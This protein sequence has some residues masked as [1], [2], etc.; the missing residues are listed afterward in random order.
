[1]PTFSIALAPL[2]HVFRVDHALGAR[3]DEFTPGQFLVLAPTPLRSAPPVA[4]SSAALLYRPP[5][6]R[7][8]PRAAV[9]APAGCIHDRRVCCRS[10]SSCSRRCASSSSCCT[11]LAASCTSW[12]RTPGSAASADWSWHGGRPRCCRRRPGWPGPARPLSAAGTRLGIDQHDVELRR[13][14]RAVELGGANVISS[15]TAWNTM[16]TASV[17]GKMSL[18]DGGGR[19]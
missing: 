12:R 1:M 8:S 7:V 14:L 15:R 4:R 18:V 11:L 5:D 17:I 2:V 16:E 6:L 3:A 9:A 13:E 19:Q 10:A